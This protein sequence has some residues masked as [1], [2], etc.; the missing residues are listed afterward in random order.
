MHMIEHP[1]RFRTG[2]R[3]LMLKGRHK[4]GIVN[5]RTVLRVTHSVEHFEKALRELVTMAT[6]GERIY[7]SAGERCMSSAIREFKRRQLDADYDDDPQRFYR[8][9][10]DRW[11]ASL[12][13]PTSQ[14]DKMWLFDCDSPADADLVESELARHY[15]RPVAPYRYASKSGAHIVVQPFNRALL[16]DASRRLIHDNA[17]I[18]WAF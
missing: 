8:A 3:V 12:M 4:D 2:T 15:D 9:I 6:D 14:A 7:G 1:E 5:E 18:L 16:T 11:V 13:Q 17:I 10:N